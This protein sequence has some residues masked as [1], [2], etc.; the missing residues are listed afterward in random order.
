MWVRA[1]LGLRRVGGRWLI[2]Q[3]HESVPFDPSTGQA[4]LDL[5]P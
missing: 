2:V 3:D 1:S 4:L 5:R